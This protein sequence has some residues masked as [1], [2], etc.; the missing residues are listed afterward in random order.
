M[1][2]DANIVGGTAQGAYT[3]WMLARCCAILSATFAL[4]TPALAQR[5][6]FTRTFDVGATPALEVTTGRGKIAVRTGAPGRIVVNG[7]VTVRFGVNVPSDAMTVAQ[8]VAAS[9]PVRHDGDL[10]V[11]STPTDGRERRAVTVSYEVEVPPAT[12]VTTTSESGETTVAGVEG[13]LAVKTQSAAITVQRTRGDATVGTGSGAV[14]LDDVGATTRVTTQSSS[15]TAEDVRGSLRVETGSGAVLIGLSGPGSIHVR[16]SSSGVRVQGLAGAADVETGSGRIE[17]TLASKA[18]PR[19]D[20]STRSGSVALEGVDVDGTV[21][22]RHVTGSVG[23]GGELV[24][25][26]SRSGSIRLSR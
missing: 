7:L 23:P 15:V 17:V 21:E 26:V 5:V 18:S 1:E 3:E 8:G 22:K 4:A 12:R 20:L 6:P 9:P 2:D 11:L 25:L 16:T 14:K 19:V 24:R 10:V 13:P